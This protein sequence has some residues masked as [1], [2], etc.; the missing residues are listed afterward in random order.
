MQNRKHKHDYDDLN[1]VGVRWIREM[2][3]FAV[4]KLSNVVVNH[5][6][7]DIQNDEYQK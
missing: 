1:P 6:F 3:G 4:M 7:N 2:N 5:I